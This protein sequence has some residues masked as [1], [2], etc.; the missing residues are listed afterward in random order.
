MLDV[1]CGSGYLTATLARLC[2]STEAEEVQV[3]GVESVGELAKLSEGNVRRADGDLLERQVV[4]IHVADGWKGWQS[5]A[6]YDAIHVGAAAEEI[7][8]ALKDQLAIGGVM[9]IPVGGVG[10]EQTLFFCTKGLEGQV[11]CEPVES[12]VFVPLIKD[13]MG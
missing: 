2:E 10:C 4:E 12:V 13:P 1:G 7:P 6:P 8:Q 5:K 9:V 11:N 3:V